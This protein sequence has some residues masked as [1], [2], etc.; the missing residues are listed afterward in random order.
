MLGTALST[1]AFEGSFE[2]PRLKSNIVGI[3]EGSALLCTGVILDNDT[4]ITAKHCLSSIKSTKRLMRL[5]LKGQPGARAL[6]VFEHGR[7]DIALLKTSTLSVQRPYSGVYTSPLKS[8]EDIVI[9]GIGDN[10]EV[11]F[12]HSRVRASVGSLSEIEEGPLYLCHGDSGAAIFVKQN[13]NYLLAG[14]V[15]RGEE[16]CYGKGTFLNLKEVF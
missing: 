16:G 9:G 7:L 5:T 4:I 8:G 12:G 2:E 6:E 3:Y 14:I 11:V 15:L 1:S 10:G 13:D